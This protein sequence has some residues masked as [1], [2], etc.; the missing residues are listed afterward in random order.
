MTEMYVPGKESSRLMNPSAQPTAHGLYEEVLGYSRDTLINA[1]AQVESILLPYGQDGVRARSLFTKLCL[2][3]PAAHTLFG[4]KPLSE[5][6]VYTQQHPASS[7]SPLSERWILPEELQG[8]Q[9]L[10]ESAGLTSHRF[11]LRESSTEL[12]TGNG[13][14]ILLYNTHN[15]R[16]IYASHGEL[17]RQ[18]LG[19]ETTAD[20]IISLLN[21]SADFNSLFDG[22]HELKGLIIGYGAKSAKAYARLVELAALGQLGPLSSAEKMKAKLESA[23]LEP[24]F[25]K[26]EYVQLIDDLQGH[27]TIPGQFRN[28]VYFRSHRDDKESEALLQEYERTALALLTLYSS[29]GS[30]V[31]AHVAIARWCGLLP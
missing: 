22:D 18:K 23:T 30:D 11:T 25:P 4:K 12:A 29:E 7:S 17:F 20:S 19:P 26:T 3:S 10:Q 2:E 31:L 21:A 1:A 28:S 8:W 16:D 13:T 14:V 15:V 6:F 9:R 5:H 24:S 27:K